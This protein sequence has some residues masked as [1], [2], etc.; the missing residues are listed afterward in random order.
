MS[1]DIQQPPAGSPGAHAASR[2]L[3][4]FDRR[5]LNQLMQLYGR[6]VSAGEWRDY[7]IDGLSEAA[8]FSVYRRASEAPFYRIEKRPELARRQGAWSVA[9]QAGLILRRGHE[10]G[11]V[12]KLFDSRRFKV[13]D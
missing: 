11:Q 7:A 2:S 3:V 4:F 10:L 6:M 12:L 8:V 9:N 5:E 1:F 13:V